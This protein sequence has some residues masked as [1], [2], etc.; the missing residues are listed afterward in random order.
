MTFPVLLL[1]V[2]VLLGLPSPGALAE[3]TSAAGNPIAMGS[4]DIDR[5]GRVSREEFKSGA[6]QRVERQFD[7]MDANGD[8]YIDRPELDAAIEQIHRRSGTREPMQ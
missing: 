7:R 5:D 4:I 2:I 6:M 3:G 8:G 1:P